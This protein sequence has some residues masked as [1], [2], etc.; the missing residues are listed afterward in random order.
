MTDLTA[1]ADVVV[2]TKLDAWAEDRG[3]VPD[4]F[5]DFAWAEDAL[6]GM[7]REAGAQVVRYLHALRAREP[8]ASPRHGWEPMAQLLDDLRRGIPDG[9]LSRAEATLGLLTVGEAVEVREWLLGL[10][11]RTPPEPVDRLVRAILAD[12]WDHPEVA[13]YIEASKAQ[14]DRERGE[15]LLRNADQH[16]RDLDWT[17]TQALVLDPRRDP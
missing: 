6:R 12:L 15:R 1:L 9:D 3:P 5:R 11:D 10:R 16:G 8:L 17:P 2:R 14:A 4:S 13:S 7:G